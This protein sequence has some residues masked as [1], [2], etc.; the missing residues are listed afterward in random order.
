MKRL[1]WPEASGTLRDGPFDGWYRPLRQEEIDDLI[2]FHKMRREL[3]PY[4]HDAWDCDDYSEEFTYLARVWS[5][6]NGYHETTPAVGSAFVRISGRYELFDKPVDAPPGVA[7]AI[8]VIMRDDGQWFFY[9]P[10]SG[11]LQKIEGPCYEG[12]IE[13]VKIQI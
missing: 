6:R 9:E 8:N 12:V 3:I 13:V 1:L 10:Q 7:H 2:H 11:K 4:L 5:V